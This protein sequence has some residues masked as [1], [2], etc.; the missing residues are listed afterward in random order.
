MNE[1]KVAKLSD[2]ED[3]FREKLAKF[4]AQHFK[5]AWPTKTWSELARSSRNI[6]CLWRHANEEDPTKITSMAVFELSP[7]DHCHLYK[8]IVDMDYRRKK[9]A[10]SIFHK[11]GLVAANSLG[12][13]EPVIYLEVEEENDGAINFYRKLGLEQI[14]LKKKFYQNG[15]A[16]VIMQGVHVCDKP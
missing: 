2:I 3:S 11:M 10:W 14:H 7:P 16:A 13:S 1:I 8:I 9:I 15:S 12:T 4:E 5:W 6:I